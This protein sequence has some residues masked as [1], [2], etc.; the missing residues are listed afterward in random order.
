MKYDILR[1]EFARRYCDT[2]D[3]SESDVV[4]ALRSRGIT[5][6][7]Q[8]VADTVARQRDGRARQATVIGK[9]A[10]ESGLRIKHQAPKIPVRIDGIDYDPAD[11]SRF[12]DTPLHYVYYHDEGM[13]ILQ[14]TTDR[15]QVNALFLLSS[16]I[17]PKG[18]HWT[19]SNGWPA[20]ECG[21]GVGDQPPATPTPPPEPPTD[22]HSVQMFSDVNFEGDWFWLPRGFEWPR[23]SKVSRNTFLWSSG[24]WNDQI[25]S[26]G[27]TS[28]TVFYFEHKQFQGS[29]LMVKGGSYEQWLDSIGWND[30]ISSVRYPP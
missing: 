3:V 13:P 28:G 10:I 27:R 2:V 24:D 9:E 5:S 1:R 7:E 6:L 25:S 20:W 12:D 16:G 8:L 14:A 11:I 15:N 4:D 21:P 22:F 18:C 26:V 29:S 19:A 17:Q 23:L 30:R